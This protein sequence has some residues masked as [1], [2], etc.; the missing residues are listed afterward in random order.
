MKDKVPPDPER[1]D[2]DAEPLETLPALR[3][4]GSFGGALGAAMFGLEA[5]LRR[6]PPAQVRVKESQP[7]RG[8][9][10]SNDGLI[11]EFPETPSQADRTRTKV[12]ATDEDE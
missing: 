12:I 6:E 1:A 4:S 9:S 2:D 11:I 8:R 3:G 10:G 7:Q 5:A